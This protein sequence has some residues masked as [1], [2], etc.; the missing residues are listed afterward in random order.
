MNTFDSKKFIKSLKE[1]YDAIPN[2][3]GDNAAKMMVSDSIKSNGY[4]P[5]EVLDYLCKEAGFSGALTSA[6]WKSVIDNAI[7]GG[8]PVAKNLVAFKSV[9]KGK[10]SDEELFKAAAQGCGNNPILLKDELLLDEYGWV[11]IVDSITKRVEK[12]KVEKKVEEPA[13]ETKPA[14]KT[15]AKKH[16]KGEKKS[17]KVSMASKRKPITL[18]HKVTGE[19]KTWESYSACD[20]ELTNS[21]GSASQVVNGGLNSIKGEWFLFKGEAS[22]PVKMEQPKRSYSRGKSINQVVFYKDG[23]K[24]VV[25][26]FDSITDASKATGIPHS[27]ISKCVSGTKGYNTPD[28]FGWELA[29]VGA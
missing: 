28:G 4:N 18:I 23:S 10:N 5:E 22:A 29:E 15:V 8:Y 20:A 2:I 3:Q 14:V 11:K 26:T 27:S 1:R 16:T 9:L 17:I 19:I 13:V 21:R 24:V 7:K 6:D 25:R 12:T